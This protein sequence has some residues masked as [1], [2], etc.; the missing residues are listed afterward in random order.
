M[1]R[2]MVGG[3]WE[4]ADTSWQK[5]ECEADENDLIRLANEH[6]FDR[7]GIS[8]FKA[9]MLCELE[10]QIYYYSEVIARWPLVFN[11]D[12]NNRLLDKLK[13]QKKA[14]LAEITGG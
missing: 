6:G 1:T 10:A 8:A 9:F 4:M 11:T 7:H 2:A 3:S 13:Q 14:L 12:A 5:I